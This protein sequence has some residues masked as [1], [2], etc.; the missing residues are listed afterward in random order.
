MNEAAPWREQLVDVPLGN[1]LVDVVEN[2]HSD[3]PTPLDRTHD[4]LKSSSKAVS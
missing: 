1:D 2:M 3:Q 4:V